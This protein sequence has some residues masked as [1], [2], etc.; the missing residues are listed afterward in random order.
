MQILPTI[1][2]TTNNCIKYGNSIIL[3]T[4]T[5]LYPKYRNTE[6]IPVL[7][8]MS[9]VT[10]FLGCTGIVVQARSQGEGGG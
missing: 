4:I 3:F 10:I 9:G 2:M 5:P 7:P 1:V 6:V 8:Y